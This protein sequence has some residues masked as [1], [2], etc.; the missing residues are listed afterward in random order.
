MTTLHETIDAAVRG[1]VARH[2]RLNG[3]PPPPEEEIVEMVNRVCRED[4][5]R[6][7]K[8]AYDTNDAGHLHSE[9]LPSPAP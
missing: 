6:V 4:L 1:Y 5:K 3:G 9:G 2:M 8:K 7:L